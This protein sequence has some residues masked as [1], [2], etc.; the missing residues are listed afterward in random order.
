MGQTICKLKTVSWHSVSRNARK[1]KFPS[2]AIISVKFPKWVLGIWCTPAPLC[3]FTF[4]RLCFNEILKVPAGSGVGDSQDTN[5]LYSVSQGR[6]HILTQYWGTVRGRRSLR[7]IIWMGVARNAM[8]PEALRSACPTVRRNARCRKCLSYCMGFPSPC[9]LTATPR[10]SIKRRLG[11]GDWL[12]K[13]ILQS[14]GQ[15]SRRK[16]LSWIAMKQRKMTP[17]KMR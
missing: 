11:F 15:F 1:V 3:T 4:Q 12:T 7:I 2:E 13:P 8:G 10:G 5:H 6:A 9:F 14:Q 17:N 16:W